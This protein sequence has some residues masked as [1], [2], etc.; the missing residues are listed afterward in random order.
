M[1]KL[2]YQELEL[3]T[4]RNTKPVIA[5]LNVTD[6]V[7]AA[8]LAPLNVLLVGDTGT[9]KTQLSADIYNG[10][11]AGNKKEGGHGIYTEAHPELDIYNE[12]FTELNIEKARRDITS[13]IDALV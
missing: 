11:F 7:K 4:Y 6:L 12:I 2:T 8:V 13:N 10:Y 9:G 3:K 5:N 1:N